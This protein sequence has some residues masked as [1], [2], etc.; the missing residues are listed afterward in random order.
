MI[1][2]KYAR[3]L[4]ATWLATITTYRPSSA[5]LCHRTTVVCA[6]ASLLRGRLQFL[7]LALQLTVRRRVLAASLQQALEEVMDLCMRVHRH[8]GDIR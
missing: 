1:D 4:I 2:T 8:E 7:E 3:W 5:A 6:I